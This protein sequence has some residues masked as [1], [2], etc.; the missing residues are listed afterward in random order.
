[1]YVLRAKAGKVFW[2]RKFEKLVRKGAVTNS[3][4]S[5][6]TPC[7]EIHPLITQKLKKIIHLK[8]EN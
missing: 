5:P 3:V 8:I 4:M 7:Q 2:L 1:M 6:P